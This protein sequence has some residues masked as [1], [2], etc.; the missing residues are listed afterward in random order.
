MSPEVRRFLD[1]LDN[2]RAVGGGWIGR[3]PAHDDGRPS[4]KV[5]LAENGRVLLHCYAGCAAEAIVAAIGLTMADLFP[6]DAPPARPKKAINKTTY[7]LR[8]ETGRLV[9]RHVRTDYDDGSKV[10]RWQRPNGQWGLGDLALTDLP[11]YGVDEIGTAG[12]IVVVEGEKA[13]D[14]L[15]RRG[16]VAVGTV[17]GAAV[18]P[19]DAAL[20]PLLDHLVPLWPDRDDPGERHMETIAADLVKLGQPPDSIRRVRWSDAPPGGDAADWTGDRDGLLALIEGAEPWP[21]AGNGAHDPDGA[22]EPEAPELP[23]FDATRDDFAALSPLVWD[24]FAR[25]N[26]PPV[27]FAFRGTA[28]RLDRDGY[29]VVPNALDVDRLL[30]ELARAADWFKTVSTKHGAMEVDSSPRPALAKDMLAGR[31]YPLPPLDRI[32]SSPV[33]GA[34][35]SLQTEPGYHAASRTYYAGDLV[36]RPVPDQPTD[37]EVGEARDWLLNE[38]LV[39]FPFS[40]DSDLAHALGELVLPYVRAMIPGPCPLHVHEAPA[41]GTGKDLL[42][43]VMCRVATGADPAT[44][45]LSE[46]A[47][48]FGKRLLSV[49]RSLPEWAVV[50][51]VSGKVE[52]DD[53]TDAISRGEY[54]NRLLG[55][56]KIL[57]LP[58]PGVWT[59]TA[60]NAQLSPD[61]VR[62]AVR[63]RLDAQMEHP[64]ARTDFRHPELKEWATDHRAELVWSCLTLVRSWVAAGRP[65]GRPTLGGFGQWARVVGGIVAHLGYGDFLADREEFAAQAD[66]GDAAERAFVALW[67]ERLGPTP[68]GLAALY[69]LAVDEDVNLDIEAPTLQGSRVKLGQQLRRMRDRRYRVADDAIVTVGDA[70]TVHRG[71]L[72]KLTEETGGPR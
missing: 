28:V 35:G 49:L 55:V 19:G 38:L 43:E 48:E 2:V 16:I 5:D 63:V 65:P 31:S 71:V 1:K 27:M 64:E 58:A 3:C 66:T 18:V 41:P 8:D 15:R 57:R 70:G 21:F 67:W 7:D 39:D 10:C 40:A 14:A 6:P 44:L 72:W 56:S 46:R 32:V 9:A 13:R 23:R 20:R 54:Q 59:M 29:R 33:F 62:R 61:L 50:P 60:N 11:L 52:N 12:G 4:L 42:A 53:L 68:S 30:H 36:L 47:E 22:P 34:D 45:V 26:D 25:A 17:T 51:N 37:A 24:A 69:P